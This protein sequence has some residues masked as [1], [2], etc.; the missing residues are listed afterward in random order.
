MH[1]TQC[2][3]VDQRSIEMLIMLT[4]QEVLSIFHN[5]LNKKDFLDMLQCSYTSLIK[6]QEKIPVHIIGAS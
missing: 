1:T 2:T 4:V 3:A 5:I 6:Y